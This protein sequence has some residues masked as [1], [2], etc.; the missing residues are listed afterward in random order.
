MTTTGPVPNLSDGRLCWL[1]VSEYVD[2][3]SRKQGVFGWFV[4]LA[5]AGVRRTGRGS[6]GALQGGSM[7]GEE[8]SEKKADYA[9]AVDDAAEALSPD[10]RR[11]LR[12]TGQVPDWFLGDVERRVTEIRRQRMHS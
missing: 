1:A 12:S 2:K 3:Q 5:G 8:M 7:R 10:E 6:G 9:L 11:R 4:L